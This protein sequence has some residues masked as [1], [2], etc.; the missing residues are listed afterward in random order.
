MYDIE[1]DDFFKDISADVNDWFDTSNYPKEHPSGIPT[2]INK[3]VPGMFKDEIGGKQIIE[4]VAL[5]AKSYSFLTHDGEEEKKCKG[6][7]K[8]VTKNH[9]SFNDYKTC[10]FGGQEQRRSM[11]IIRSVHHD[12]YSETINKIAL[13]ASNDKSVISEDNIHMLAYGHWRLRE[14]SSNKSE[15]EA[16]F[17]TRPLSFLSK[18]WC[19]ISISNVV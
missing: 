11:N 8:N 10:L 5:R 7:K 18:R 13:S 12:I 14:S 6:I 3:K 19:G 15:I 1:T 9:I 4:L 2:G 16:K 17:R